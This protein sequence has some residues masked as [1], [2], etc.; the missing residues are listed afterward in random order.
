MSANLVVYG[1]QESR[2]LKTWFS[3]PFAMQFDI[4]NG[5][6]ASQQTWIERQGVP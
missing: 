1:R 2:K 3:P 5:A 6:M 4:A